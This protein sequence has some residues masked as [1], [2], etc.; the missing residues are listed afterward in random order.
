MKDNNNYNRERMI[1]EANSFFLGAAY[2]FIQSGKPVLIL[3]RDKHTPEQVLA[4][5]GK[6]H[7]KEALVRWTLETVKH[8]AAVAFKYSHITKPEDL[9]PEEAQEIIHPFLESAGEE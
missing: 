7:P 4:M 8:A 6:T 3:M 9:T 1:K 5:L 2:S